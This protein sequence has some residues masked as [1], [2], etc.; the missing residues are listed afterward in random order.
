M[1]RGPFTAANKLTSSNV[2]ITGMPLTMCA[3]VYPTSF[4]TYG[5][6]VGIGKTG[7]G[8]SRYQLG[9]NI[10]SG[11]PF[12]S[13]VNDSGTYTDANGGSLT[14]N[15][16]NFMCAVFTSTTSRTIYLNNNAGITAATSIAAPTGINVNTI[17]IKPD[18]TEF[19]VQGFIAEVGIWN[20]ALS[21]T[22]VAQL[23]QG[24]SPAFVKNQNLITYVPLIR[25]HKELKGN[26]VYTESGS[27]GVGN[28]PKIIYKY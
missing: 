9:Y 14:L 23:A 5:V 10:T 1:S 15:T 22:E 27:V 8:N 28:H 3:W 20:I 13:V 11:A 6:V 25:D 21:S 26:N 2:P 7:T 4:S 16:W 24:F 18:G 17:G 19:N 12:A